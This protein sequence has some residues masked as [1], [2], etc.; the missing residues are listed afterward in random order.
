M[1]LMT[2]DGGGTYNLAFF[3]GPGLPLTLG[4]ASGPR[5]TP[6]LLLTPFFL[7]PSV[8]GGIDDGPGV[9]TGAGVLE[10]DSD[11]LSP[12]E[13]VATGGGMAV[14]DAESFDGDSSLIGGGV[15]S[16]VCNALGDSFKVMIMLAFEDFR[17]AVGVV[18]GLVDEAIVGLLIEERGVRMMEGTV[19]D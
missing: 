7:T 9:P 16:K 14:A 4:G 5:A 8:G 19:A 15:D 11:G 13:L 3:L 18:A 12:F 2:G 17:R 10:F 6:E 1:M